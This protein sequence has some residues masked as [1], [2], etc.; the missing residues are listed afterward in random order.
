MTA[1][2]GTIV[3]VALPRIQQDLSFSGVAVSWVMSFYLVG[4]GGSLLVAGRLAD[5][6]GRRRMFLTGLGLFTV[7]SLVSGLAWS[8]GVL[9]AA[10]F[11]QGIA[12]AIIAPTMLPLLVTAFNESWARSRAFGV[13]TVIGA[14]S[15]TAG[16]LVGGLLVETWGWRSIFLANVPVGAA[17][18]VLGPVLL[19]ENGD[20]RSAPPISV[21]RAITATAALALLILAVAGPACPV[22]PRRAVL[23]P[24][25]G[26]AVLFALFLWSGARARIRLTP[27]RPGHSSTYWGGMAILAV[28]GAAFDGLLFLLTLHTQQERNWPA[29]FFALAM[30]VMTLASVLG[31]TAGQVL[32]VH[33]GL[34]ATVTAGLAILGIGILVLMVKGAGG[35]ARDILVGIFLSGAGLGMT[36]VAAQIAVVSSVTGTQSTQAGSL[37]DT[38]FSIGGAAGLTILSTLV[39]TQRGLTGLGRLGSTELRFA[40]AATTGLVMVGLLVALILLR[41]PTPSGRQGKVG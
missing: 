14:F 16:L 3:Y 41:R 23:V 6:V 9:T 38:S 22:C 19:R 12:A 37:A 25:L 28:T 2:D 13:W 21:L 40:F 4:F 30:T 24:L 39:V 33:R 26:S 27:L 18:L 32:A 10:R 35:P 11:L 1:M 31:S 7:A 17:L 29:I 36:F 15:G 34:R 20:M 5:V 8:T